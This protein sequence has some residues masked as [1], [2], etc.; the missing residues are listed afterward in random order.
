MKNSFNKI[1]SLLVHNKPIISALLIGVF[2]SVPATAYFINQSK[3]STEN[4]TSTQQDSKPNNELAVDNVDEVKTNPADS[5]QTT[6]PSNPQRNTTTSSTPSQS[7]TNSNP[8]TAPTPEPTPKPTPQY[9][10]T[11]WVESPGPRQYCPYTAPASWSNDFLKYP[12][13]QAINGGVNTVPCPSWQ[14]VR[15]VQGNHNGQCYFYFYTANLQRMVNTP[16]TGSTSA[17]C[18]V[19]RPI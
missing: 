2:V 11:C 6:S 7:S 10:E 16:D 12:C 5:Q 8:T 9:L 18:L 19:A 14:E 15:S 3:S 13:Q 1:K 4:Q 17:D